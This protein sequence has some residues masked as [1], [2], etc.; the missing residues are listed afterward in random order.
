MSLDT[1]TRLGP[2]E[3]ISVIGAGGMGEV[4]RA[5][6][7]RLDRTVAIK[8]LP[9][10]LSSNPDLKQRFEREARTISSLSHAHICALYDIGL[11][12]GVDYLVMEFLE[13]ETLAQRLNRGSLSAE[14]VLRY[15]I[16]I[17]DALDKA[18]RQGI[19]HRDLKPGNIM[20]TKSGVKLLDFGLAKLQAPVNQ[21]LLSGVSTFPTEQRDLTAEG[22]ILG[23]IQYMSPEQLEGKETDARTDIFALGS[24]LYEMATGKRAFSGKSQ[25]SLIAAILSSEP[26]PIS[27][28]QP[29]SPPALDRVVKTCLAKDPD[30]RWQTAHD[31]MLELKW[32][33]EGGSQAGIPKPVLTH[34]RHREWLAWLL[35][36][37]F[38][39]ALAGVT[40]LYYSKPKEETRPLHV[41]VLSPEVGN[42]WHSSIS[43][44]GL[45]LAIVA[46]DSSAKT[47]LWIRS[48][49]NNT[50]TQLPETEGA[51][52]P[53]WSPDGSYIGFFADNSLKKMQIPN[54][55]PEVICDVEQEPGSGATWGKN[56]VILFTNKNVIYRVNSSGG[57]SQPVTK[58]D[59][60]HEGH[61]WPYFLPDGDHFLYLDDAAKTEFHTLELASLDSGKTE[62]LLTP[63]I[64]DIAYAGG[65]VFFV[66]SGT[67]MAQRLDPKTFHL[68][69]SPITIADQIAEVFANH[70]FD[71]S[72]SANGTIAYQQQNPTSQLIW[73]DRNGL[74]IGSVGDPGRYV[75]MDLSP[76]NSKAAVEILDANGRNGEIW[77]V[78]LSRGIST[79][80]T[81][82]PSADL[83]PVWS[84]DGT[85]IVF[86]SNRKGKFLDLFQKATNQSSTD[87]FLKDVQADSFPTSWTPD[88]KFLV[89]QV[90]DQHAKGDIWLLPTTS[91]RK[92][93]PLIRTEFDEVR[94]QVSPDGHW[95]AYS[96]DESGR[97]EIYVQTMPP[98]GARYQVSNGGG[99]DSRWRKDGKEIFFISPD[100]KLMAAQVLTTEPFETS[101]TKPLFPIQE[102]FMG[103]ERGNYAVSN[104]GNRFLINTVSDSPMGHAIHLITNWTAKQDQ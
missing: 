73:Y 54:G 61:R 42:L 87:E 104:D 79:R 11:Q 89:Y 85:K 90:F 38:F 35:A 62:K 24:V 76:D 16:Q 70:R 40:F 57:A 47:H 33:A 26:Q 72:V 88:G 17:A 95:I 64:S 78:E 10:H 67:L 55:R 28:I 65:Y 41:S 19:V 37:L 34:R 103:P 43:P 74:K 58:L 7:T 23:T 56:G 12:D 36:G 20:I 44:D 99:M 25:A 32:I 83:C 101:I 86:G 102:R 2:Y 52:W 27:I 50:A 9:A 39:V 63:F 69:G 93:V 15:G 29:M 66:R 75:A 8:I 45:T 71:F 53:F 21:P 81:F 3:L 98:S 13:G 46:F 6:D 4:Y 80:F 22:T 68:T 97:S 5:K 51:S 59:A 60:N 91:D 82:D 14:L 96:S 18:H 49:A 77:V 92:P 84:P 31:V 30:D 100:N 1:G 94:A 48:L